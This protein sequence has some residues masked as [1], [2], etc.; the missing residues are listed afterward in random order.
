MKAAVC[1]EFKKPLSIEQVHLAEPGPGEVKVRIAACAI[2]HSDILFIEGAWGGELPAVFGHEAAG[3]VEEVGAG[4]GQVEPGDHVVVTL[5]RS[6][7]HCHF[8]ARGE[9]PLCETRLPLDLRSPLGGAD[10]S[11]I[12]QGLRTAA[13]AEQVVVH[14]SQVA[15]IPREV[16]LESASLLACGVIT[17]LGAVL[18]TAAMRPG[19]HAV[20]IGTGGVGLNCV[21]GA[22]ICGAGANIAVDLSDRKLAAARTLGASHTINPAQEDVRGAVRSLTGGR[23]ADY[24]FVAAGSA[25]A[26]EQGARLL[27]R[28]GTLVVVGMTA[29]GVQVRLEALDIA[30]GALRILGSKMGSVRMPLDVQMLAGWYLQGRLKLDELISARYPLERINDAIASAAGGEALRNVITF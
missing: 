6:C 30:D 3:T 7:G 25:A 21:Q 29:E 9:H 13:F 15:A 26:I 10:G 12:R 16:P 8:C 27:R 17:G 23:G 18:N 24:V 19:G 5:L 11:P 2:C 28:G 1:R 22:A 20:T 4:V 14:A